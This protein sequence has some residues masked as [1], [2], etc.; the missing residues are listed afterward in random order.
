MFS[1]F[2]ITKKKKKKKNIY[3][4]I[5]ICNVFYIIYIITLKFF[6]LLKIKKLNKKIKI[7]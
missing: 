6:L 5:Y 2:I 7:I 1:L 4:Y 3:I